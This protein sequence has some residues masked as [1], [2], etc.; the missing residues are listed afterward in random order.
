MLKASRN[1]PRKKAN[2]THFL[3]HDKEHIL[4]SLSRRYLLH[5]Y[6]NLLYAENT[7]ASP[8]SSTGPALSRPVHTSLPLLLQIAGHIVGVVQYAMYSLFLR[9][10][11]SP[12]SPNDLDFFQTSRKPS[13][14]LVIQCGRPKRISETQSAIDFLLV[15][16]FFFS[17]VRH[18]HRSRQRW[19]AGVHCGVYWDAFVSLGKRGWGSRGV[20]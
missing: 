20:F 10:L 3:F 12:R 9:H 6:T 13:A 7:P 5:T 19:A 15:N 4:D 16:F 17:H 14:P 1:E 11:L 18:H 2:A 8:V